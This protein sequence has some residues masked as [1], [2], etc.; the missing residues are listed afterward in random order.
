MEAKT[1]PKRPRVKRPLTSANPE[2]F[3]HRFNYFEWL[4]YI[5]NV[6]YAKADAVAVG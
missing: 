2:P 5:H 1:K 4:L 3:T 6:H